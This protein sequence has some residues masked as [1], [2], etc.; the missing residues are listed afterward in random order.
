MAEW[1]KAA[2]LKAAEGF[3]PSGGSNPSP[4]AIGAPLQR[5][6][7]R[8]AEGARLLSGCGVNSPTAG[9]NPALSAIF[10]R[11]WLCHLLSF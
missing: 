7:D 1:S 8:V 4:S 6:G 2:A 11:F 9:S 10:F 5:R 3:T